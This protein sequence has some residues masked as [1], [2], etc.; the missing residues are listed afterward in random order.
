MKKSIAL[1]AFAAFSTNLQAQYMIVGKDSISLANFKKEYKYGLENIGVEK[2]IKSTEDFLLLQQFAAEKKADTT[3]AFREKM[4][5]R[6]MELRKEFFFPKEIIDPILQD[7]I[8][9]NQIEKKVQIFMVKR[10]P[11]DTTDYQKVYEEVKAGKIT[12]EDAITKYAKTETTAVFVKPGAID[13]S[14]Y[15]ELKTLGDNAYTKLHKTAGF[16]SFAKVLASRPTLGYLVFGTISYP[17]DDNADAMKTKIYTDLKSGKTFP[18]VAKLYGANE[19]EKNNG[20]VVIGSPTL[21]DEVYAQLKNQKAGFYTPEPLLFGENYFIFNIYNVEPYAINPKNRDFFLREMN[22]TLYSELVQ[23]KM[24]AFLKKDPSYKEFPDFAT[25]KKS[26]AVFNTAKDDAVLYQY[27]GYKTTVADIRKLVGE[28]KDEV[29]KLTPALWSEALGGVQQQDLMRFY[30][31]EFTNQKA[32]KTELKEFQKGLFSDYVFSKYISDEIA[33]NPQWLTDYYNQHK[34]DFVWG[35]RAEGRVAIIADDKLVPEISKSMKDPKKWEEL[36]KKYY[37]KLND[38]KQILVHFEKG[39]MAENADVFTKYKV[40]FKT[41]VHQT[42]MEARELVIAIDKI[43]PPTT[44]T[45]EEAAEMLKD[46]VT[47]QK[48]REII[49]TQ[50]AKTT[51]TIQP[52]FVTDLEKNFKK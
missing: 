48:L 45:Q 1:L 15:Q 31:Q 42:K 38:Q 46:A 6:E 29:S 43:L 18:E 27:K 28:K 4:G 14:L 37:G 2:T 47:E 16:V 12:M 9:D 7:F 20:G 30:S 21:P 10:D 33:K 11:A 35:N 5:D 44:M 32:I 17:K 49:A 52:A 41:G 24:V 51:I 8:K 23:D 40:P 13:N 19:H 3:A 36:N 22:N 50:K 39:E 34:T 26:Y 25:V